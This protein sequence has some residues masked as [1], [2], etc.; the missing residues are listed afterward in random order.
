M[1]KRPV[2]NIVDIHNHL[3]PGVDDGA[4]TFEESLRHLRL[5]HD[6]GVTRLAVSPHLFERDGV[7]ARLD[8]LEAGFAALQHR[9][10]GRTDVPRLHFSQEILCPTP[11]A[12]RAVFADARAGVANSHYALVEF[13]F[14][15]RSDCRP[16]IAA[17]LGCGKRMIT[18]HPE[19]FRRDGLPVTLEEIASWKE[20]GAL[21]QVNGGSLLGHYGAR[22][23]VRVWE[24]LHGGLADLISSDHHADYRMLSPAAVARAIVA[25]GGAEQARL[26]MSENPRRVLDDED[27][28]AVPGWADRSAA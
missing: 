9:L 7:A 18:S 23:Q 2:E 27:L 24:L 6:D 5:M 11:A 14:E 25:R 15:L 28:L 19:R 17:V 21:L 16:V 4:Q 20:A 12:A 10:A 26:L 22:I 13:G 3:L 1:G 8:E